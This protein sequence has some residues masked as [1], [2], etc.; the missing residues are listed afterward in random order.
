MGIPRYFYVEIFKKHF[1]TLLQI[2][3]RVEIPID[4]YLLDGNAIFHPICQKFFPKENEGKFDKLKRLLHKVETKEKF[5][6]SNKM[7]YSEICKEIEKRIFIIRPKKRIYIA[8]DGVAGT[9]KSNQQRQRRFMSVKTKSEEEIKEFDTNCISAGSEFMDGLSRYLD[10]YFKGKMSKNSYWSKL[11]I[12]FSNEKACGEGEHKLIRWITS[13]YDFLLKNKETICIDSPDADLLMLSLGTY[14]P[15]LFVFR[16]NIYDF[17]SC[18]Y[19]LVDISKLRV[20]MIE[21]IT[22][23]KY[24]EKDEKE[25]NEIINSFILICEYMGNDFVHCIHSLEMNKENMNVLLDLYFKAK[26]IT[27]S[28]LVVYNNGN[29]C[30][31][32]KFLKVYLKLIKDIEVSLFD[33]KSKFIYTDK[34]LQKHTDENNEIDFDSYR[35]EFYKVK[36]HITTQEEKF[37]HCDDYLKSLVFVLRYYLVGIPDYQYSFNWHYSPFFTDLYEYVINLKEDVLDYKFTFNKPLSVFE[38]LLSILPANSKNLLPKPLQVLFEPTSPIY[39]FYPIDFDSDIEGKK[40]SYQAT[41]LLNFVDIDRLK[42][43]YSK[44]D[45]SGLTE[46]EKKRNIPGKIMLYKNENGIVNRSFVGI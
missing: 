21:E 17:V 20:N 36:L 7:I 46:F 44:I 6:V 4:N 11:E 40:E 2:K 5:Q 29:Y 30:I 41:I 23:K 16:E 37:K 15:H 32:L 13:N 33:N 43:A 3:D 18:K 22:G 1:S 31:N 27:N 35:N 28:N 25:N 24:E 10:Y 26:Q 34:L 39:D 8:I 45:L 12:I 19:F 14:Y 42:D 38:Q 9:A